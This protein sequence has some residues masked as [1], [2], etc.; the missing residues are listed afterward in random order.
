MASALRPAPS[1]GVSATTTMAGGAIRRAAS[2]KP[3]MSGPRPMMLDT[4]G[5]PM[6]VLTA[7]ARAEAQAT[8]RIIGTA[9]WVATWGGTR[10]SDDAAVMAQTN[11]MVMMAAGRWRMRSRP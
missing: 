3:S 9:S 11:T 7:A 10:T 6:A 8:L 4:F 5:A 2:T 1:R